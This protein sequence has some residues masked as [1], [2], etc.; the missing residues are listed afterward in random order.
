MKFD[1]RF[2]VGILFTIYGVLLAVY[3]AISDKAIYTKSLGIN[4]NLIWGIV[5]LVFGVLM[6]FFAWRGTQKKG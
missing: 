6:F 5:M 3:G 1:L 4:I 2:P